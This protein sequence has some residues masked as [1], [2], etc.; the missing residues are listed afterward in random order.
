MHFFVTQ[1]WKQFGELRVYA[2]LTVLGTG[3]SIITITLCF[4]AHMTNS[5][6]IGLR[7]G[8]ITENEHYKRSRAY[9]LSYFPMQRLQAMVQVYKECCVCLYERAWLIPE[10]ML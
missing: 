10:R 3:H 9:E 8:R 2:T 1:L 4:D 7:G 6:R 5:T